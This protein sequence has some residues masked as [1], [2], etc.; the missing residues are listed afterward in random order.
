MVR[1]GALPDP[2]WRDAFTTVPRHLFVPSF[3]S[4][5]GRARPVSPFLP[6]R[7]VLVSGEERRQVPAWLAGVYADRALITHVDGQPVETRF[8][9]SGAGIGWPSAY[10]LEPSVL[11]RMLQVLDVSEKHRVLEICTNTGYSTAL[12]AHRLGRGRLTMIHDDP[13]TGRRT[14][15]RL[16]RLGLEVCVVIGRPEHD[17]MVGRVNRILATGPRPYLPPAWI[18]QTIK[19]GMILTGLAGGIGGAMLVAT[20]DGGG[21]VSGYFLNEV[22]GPTT[23]WQPRPSTSLALR[24]TMDRPGEVG[25]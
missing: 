16:R 23:T 19:G 11:A 14:R 13:Y 10:A 1:R 15:D 17:Q 8:A 2:R 12:L 6:P 5:V 25:G 20:V 4:H 22:P 18:R 3:A 9:D 7:L 24:H 21:S